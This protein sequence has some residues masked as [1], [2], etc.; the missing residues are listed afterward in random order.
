MA[1]VIHL[2]LIFLFSFKL[3]L[4][5]A[6]SGKTNSNI[7]VEQE[8]QVDSVFSDPEELVSDL[9]KKAVD[10]ENWR[11]QDDFLIQL[12]NYFD[13]S[14][15]AR[16]V[17]GRAVK[18]ID[19]TQLKEFIA[20]FTETQVLAYLPYFKNLDSIKL[21]RKKSDKNKTLLVFSYMLESGQAIEIGIH[22]RKVEGVVKIYDMQIDG[23]RIL[24]IW[25]AE[26]RSLI[27]SKGFEAVMNSLRDK[28]EK[29]KSSLD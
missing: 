16:F 6:D 7:S 10:F 23:V 1:K 18:Q 5:Q 13:F 21:L 9:I 19:A 8:T 2:C 12:G 14:V 24:M 28:L 3:G 15:M 25:R 11:K 29:A 27:R 17:L 22:V 4:V 26:F 20:L